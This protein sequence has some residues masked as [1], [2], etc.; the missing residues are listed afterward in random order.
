M[1]ITDVNSGI[2]KN[3][4]RKRLGRGVGSS[5]GKTA[6]RGHKGEGSRN[7]NNQGVQFEGGQMPLVRR[8]PKR[9]FTN[10]DAVEVFNLNV[11]ELDAMFDDGDVVSVELLKEVGL[12]KR[13][14]MDT[15]VCLKILGNGEITKKLTVK[16]HKFSKS[17]VE[18]LQAAGC[19]VEVAA[20]KKPVVKN[21][22]KSK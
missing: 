12:I 13:S 9:G 16:A 20:G 21:K 8:I 2:T 4:T 10:A 17:A 19:T 15:F 14:L 18:K 7:G 3:K 5:Q 11:D 6:G 1:N 22:M